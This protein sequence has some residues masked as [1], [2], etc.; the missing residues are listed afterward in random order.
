MPELAPVTSAVLPERSDAV[1][2]TPLPLLVVIGSSV[3]KTGAA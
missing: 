2:G 1:L 3:G